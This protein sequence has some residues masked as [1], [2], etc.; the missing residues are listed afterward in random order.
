[1]ITKKLFGEINGQLPDRDDPDEKTLVAG[2]RC[3]TCDSSQLYIRKANFRNG[4]GFAI[5]VSSKCETVEELGIDR[6]AAHCPK[7]DRL[8]IVERTTMINSHERKNLD[9]GHSIG[10]GG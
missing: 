4:K 3:P 2:Q 8:A 7:C 10:W 1:M 9:C 5:C 6:E